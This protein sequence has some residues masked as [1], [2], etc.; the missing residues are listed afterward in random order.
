M[1]R[2]VPGKSIGSPACRMRR[3]HEVEKLRAVV[4]SAAQI[5]PISDAGLD[6]LGQP[7]KLNASD[8]GL[9]VQRLEIIAQMRIDKFMIV[10]F[11]Q[12]SKLPF[13]SFAAGIVFAAGTP[14]IASPIPK[15]LDDGPEFEAADH[16]DRA[17]FTEC[18]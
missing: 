13:E 9:D 2:T 8:G 10:A 5:L 14:A 12:I 4:Q 16:V 11:R 3:Q 1:P 15:T 18:E 7:L 6:E 17:S